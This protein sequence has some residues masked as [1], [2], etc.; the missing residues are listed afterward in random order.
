MVKKASSSN[1]RVN[2]RAP[3][4]S[5]AEWAETYGDQTVTDHARLVAAMKQGEFGA[6]TPK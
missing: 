3:R 2:L 4:P 1:D 5:L 6:S